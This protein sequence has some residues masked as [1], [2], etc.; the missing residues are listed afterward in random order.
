MERSPRAVKS[1]KEESH[2]PRGNR[3]IISL[4]CGQCKNRNY[5]TSKNKRKSQDKLE[6]SKFCPFCRKHTDHKEGKV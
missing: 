4:E 1:H 3:T 5:T 2:M 6:L